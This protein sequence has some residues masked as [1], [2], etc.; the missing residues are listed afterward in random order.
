MASSSDDEE[1][2]MND[3]TMPPPRKPPAPAPRRKTALRKG[4]GLADWNQLVRK[5]TDLAQLRGQPVRRRIAWSEIK[6][7]KDPH[8]GWVVLKGK[9]YRLSPYTAYHPGG[10]RILQKVLGKDV[11]ALYDKY[12]RW[13]NEDGLIGKLLIGYVDNSRS[14]STEQTSSYLP[15]S[16]SLASDGFARPAPRVPKAVAAAQPTLG[17]NASGTDD[18]DDDDGKNLWES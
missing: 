14:T 18:D 6:Q 17:R 2:H 5:S 1:R 13:V 9:V 8:D 10:E 4:F 15:A 16:A 3:T 12:H 11:T 7:H